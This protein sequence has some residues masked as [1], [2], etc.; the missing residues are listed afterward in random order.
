MKSTLWILV[1]VTVA[2]LGTAGWLLWENDQ[3]KQNKALLEKQIA[4]LLEQQSSLEEHLS[5]KE[6]KQI[7]LSQALD[8]EIEKQ[9]AM[10][11]AHQET[12]EEFKLSVEEEKEEISSLHGKL[13]EEL[14]NEITNR[15]IKLQEL[16]GR[17][18]LSMENK[19]LFPSGTA[20]LGDRGSEVLNKISSALSETTDH[21]IRVEGH[22][23]DVPLSGRGLYKNNWDLSAAR[24][25][26]VVNEL[27]VTQQ[28]N[29]RDIEAVAMGEFHPIADNATKEGRAQNRR[30]EIYLSPKVKDPSSI[31]SIPEDSII[32]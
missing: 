23:D 14:Q 22:T 13:V 27:L 17:I 8:Q 7:Q 18:S 16:N 29:A 12:L 5:I 24:A 1:A 31:K 19:I 3:L 9:E 30:I 6:K 25:L 21:I 11:Q 2:L 20:N 26:S 28:L 4:E 10:I 32:D 15:E